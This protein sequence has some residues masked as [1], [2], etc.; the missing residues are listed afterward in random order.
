MLKPNSHLDSVTFYFI[1]IYLFNL[2]SLNVLLAQWFIMN[3]RKT[4]SAIPACWL[5][6]W[7]FMGGKKLTTD[8]TCVFQYGPNRKCHNLQ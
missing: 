6:E 8:G 4:C 2:I 7:N 1:F 3:M 5:Q